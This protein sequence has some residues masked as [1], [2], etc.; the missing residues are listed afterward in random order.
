LPQT[1]EFVRG[2]GHAGVSCGNH[3]TEKP[4]STA[5]ISWHCC[6]DSDSPM[7]GF[8]QGITREG[9]PATRSLSTDDHGQYQLRIR[10]T[11]QGNGEKEKEGE[12][13]QGEGR[14]ESFGIHGNF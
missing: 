2:S 6:P 14:E 8:H 13:A 12:K 10:E 9:D 5:V 4:H 11:P 1:K 7:G 3:P